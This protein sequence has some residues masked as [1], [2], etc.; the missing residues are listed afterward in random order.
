MHFS[1][2]DNER[3]G[4]LA[5][6]LVVFTVAFIAGFGALFWLTGNSSLSTAHPIQHS[7]PA[8]GPPGLPV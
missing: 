4:S 8:A 6:L 1:Y 7:A 3:S 5:A 2:V